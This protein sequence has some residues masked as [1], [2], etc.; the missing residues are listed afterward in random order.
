MIIIWN[1]DAPSDIGVNIWISW[2]IFGVGFFFR[3]LP[4]HV[5]YSKLPGSQKLGR[6]LPKSLSLIFIA[7]EFDTDASKDPFMAVEAD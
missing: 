7:L 4:L 5:R 1:N 3:A 2:R 6:Y